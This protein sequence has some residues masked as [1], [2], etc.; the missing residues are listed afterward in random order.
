MLKQGTVLIVGAGASCEFGLPIGD[1]LK[2]QLSRCLHFED[3]NG[4]DD[5]RNAIAN[6]GGSA[7]MNEFFSRCRLLRHGV[8]HT[9]S[10]DDFVENHRGDEVLTSAAKLAIA[11]CILDAERVSS[12]HFDCRKEVLDPSRVSKAWVSA[13]F[14]LLNQGVHKSA[15]DSLFQN[16]SVVCFNYDRC[17]EQFLAA[18][19]Q[20]NYGVTQ[21]T[22]QELV[23]EKLHIFRPYGSLG[24]LFGPAAEYVEFGANRLPRA[25]DVIRRLKTYSEQVEDEKGLARIRQ[26][27]KD[28]HTLVFLG[29]AY[30]E[31]NMKLLF[32]EDEIVNR[33]RIFA[34]RYG[35]KSDDDLNVVHSYFLK[36][37]KRTADPQH[38]MR[39]FH[40]FSQKC[41]D[42]FEE[43]KLSLRV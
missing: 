29:N 25:E 32:P 17:I 41:A 42:L 38:T 4:D 12:L 5:V 31:N 33:K 19:I 27:I 11:K 14:R 8:L 23:R 18:A 1:D 21:E 30:H 43:Y 24:A 36:F 9:A 15:I 28:A 26:T 10:I 2:V 22:A 3:G 39:H 37:N 13:F 40:K 7:R 34:T 20:G 6:L 35:I 16:V